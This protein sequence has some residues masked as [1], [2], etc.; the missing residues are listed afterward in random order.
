MAQSYFI[1]ATPRSGSTLLCDLLTQTG[2]AGRPN[3]FY[4]RQSIIDFVAKFGLVAQEPFQ[5]VT[6][7]REYLGA[8]AKHSDK[9]GSVIGIRLMWESVPEMTA[10]LR[11]IFPPELSDTQLLTQAFGAPKFI[12]LHRK[13]K[14]AQAVSRTKAEQTGLWHL[15]ADG[16]ERERSKAHQLPVYDFARIKQFWDETH[17]HERLWK[18]WFEANTIKPIHVFYE[19]LSKNPTQEL[20]HILNALQLG[21]NLVVTPSSQSAPLADEV[22]RDWCARFANDLLNA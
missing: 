14:I 12:R 7:E 2:V 4:R 15:H 11:T 22:S 21:S 1:C 13:D 20:S 18:G 16:R 5:G 19:N 9:N 3:S 10:R 6:F 8:I 17:N